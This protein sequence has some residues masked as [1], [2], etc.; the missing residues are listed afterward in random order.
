MACLLLLL[1]LGYLGPLGRVAWTRLR[2]A[3][4]TGLAAYAEILSQPV[5]LDIFLRTLTTAALVTLI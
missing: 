1:A 5:F 3:G 4:L 2:R